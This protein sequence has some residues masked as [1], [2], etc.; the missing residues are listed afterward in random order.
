MLLRPFPLKSKLDP[1][2]DKDEQWRVYRE[3]IIKDVGISIF[4]FGNKRNKENQFEL[5]N[6]VY[7]E[8]EIAKTNENII[9]PLGV[10][11][12]KTKE[13]F[14]EVKSNIEQYPYLV[15]YIDKLEVCD[16]VDELVDIVLKIIKST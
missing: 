16:D 11:G 2:E 7:K 1:N 8:Y 6:G 4:V 5:A 12:G 9:I 10:T 14:D 13:I 15:P 3:D